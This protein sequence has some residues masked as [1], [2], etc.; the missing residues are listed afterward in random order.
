MGYRIWIKEQIT[1][2]HDCHHYTKV[3]K[4][5]REALHRRKMCGNAGHGAG[6]A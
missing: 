4:E 6:H 5:D 1:L 2:I 3:K